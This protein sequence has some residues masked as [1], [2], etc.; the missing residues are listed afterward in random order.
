M[1]HFGSQLIL[2]VFFTKVGTEMT[3]ELD[4]NYHCPGAEKRIEISHPE[5]RLT[6]SL[7][8]ARSQ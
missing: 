4:N 3:K 5:P 6:C 1:P 7:Y 8:Q 2:R